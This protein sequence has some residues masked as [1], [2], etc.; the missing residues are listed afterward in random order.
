MGLAFDK[1][2]AQW[3]Y[4][5]FNLF[6]EKLGNQIGIKLFEMAGFKYAE[7]SVLGAPGVSWDGLTDDIVPLLNHSD[8][9]GE[10]TAEECAKVGPRLLQMVADWPD[11]HD[12]ENAIELANDMIAIAANGESLEF[13]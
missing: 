12:K 11:G 9:D 3:S 2:N 1:S 5:G 7:G 4:R 13:C 8:C 10:L 6:R